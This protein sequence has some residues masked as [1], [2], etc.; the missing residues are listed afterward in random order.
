MKKKDPIFNLHHYYYSH[1][2]E[3]AA[4]PS[5]KKCYI[6]SLLIIQP[7]TD[8]QGYIA[9]ICSRMYLDLARKSQNPNF[10]IGILGFSS[11]NWDFD[12]VNTY[13]LFG[14]PL[15]EFS[16]S[17]SPSHKHKHKTNIIQNNMNENEFASLCTESSYYCSVKQQKESF[18]K[19]PRCSLSSTTVTYIHLYVESGFHSAAVQISINPFRLDE[20]PK[21][22]FY[23]FKCRYGLCCRKAPQDIVATAVKK[24][25]QKVS[26]TFYQ[27]GHWDFSH[28]E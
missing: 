12:Y 11:K 27:L 18:K 3:T 5:V 4:G 10:K 24:T 2:Q 16:S 15:S 1:S 21:Q 28:D 6:P 25:V 8:M 7:G 13:L 14:Y 22:T 19:T 26:D 9:G 23:H 20:Y 17:F